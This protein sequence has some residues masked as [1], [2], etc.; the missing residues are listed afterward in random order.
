VS[1]RMNWERVN[2][3]NRSWR[4][5]RR[6]PSGSWEPYQQSKL[7]LWSPAEATRRWLKGEDKSPAVPWGKGTSKSA[8]QRRRRRERAAMERRPTRVR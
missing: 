1:G 6:A 8:R 2:R 5:A 3:E 4:E 7:D